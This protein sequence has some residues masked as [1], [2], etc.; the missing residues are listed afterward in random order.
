MKPDDDS[1]A[2]ET[3]MTEITVHPDG[4]VCIFGTSR[5]V[6]DVLLGLN[7]SSS[8]LNRLITHVRCLESLQGEA[9]EVEVNLA[10]TGSD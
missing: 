6:L 3:T 4:R 8:K 5:Q 2:D 7:P 10:C 9:K 1:I